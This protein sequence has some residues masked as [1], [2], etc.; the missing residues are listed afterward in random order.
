MGVCDSHEE[1]V[2]AILEARQC[3]SKN[4]HSDL[5][6]ESGSSNAIAWT[7]NNKGYHWKFQFLVNEI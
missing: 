2:L 5:I 4:F 3:F 6:M 7:S 1:E